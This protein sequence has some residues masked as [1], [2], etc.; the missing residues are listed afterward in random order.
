MPAAVGVP[1]R[2]MGVVVGRLWAD[3]G[4]WKELDERVWCGRVG[5]TQGARL[6]AVFFATDWSAIPAGNGPPV[7]AVNEFHSG[8][9]DLASKPH[10]S[11]DSCWR[12]NYGGISGFDRTVHPF[13]L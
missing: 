13:G 11:R 4:L 10:R 2:R 1:L 8:K 9:S 12:D 3:V 6:H 7:V 5:T